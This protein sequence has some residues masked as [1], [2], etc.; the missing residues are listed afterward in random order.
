MDDATYAALGSATPDPAAGDYAYAYGYT[1]EGRLSTRE[2]PGDLTT[3]DWADGELLSETAAGVSVT[4]YTRDA[5][6]PRLYQRAIGDG[7]GNWR[8][9]TYAYG[10][11]QGDAERAV[12]KT[13]SEPADEAGRRA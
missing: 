8:T 5:A 3:W 10:R 9:T 6:T 11:P 2:G 1:D 13:R 4:T 7:A 12:R